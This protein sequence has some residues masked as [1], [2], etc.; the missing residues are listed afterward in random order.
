MTGINQQEMGLHD[1]WRA[2]VRRRWFIVVSA[3][4]TVVPAVALSV[5]QSPVYQ[6]EARMLIQNLPS[7]SV[8]SSGGGASSKSV[9]NEIQVLEGDVVYQRL[10]TDLGLGVDPPTVTGSVVGDTDV[11]AVTVR[12]GDPVTAAILANEYI[13]AY[14][15]STRSQAVQGM[16]AAAQELQSKITE[17]QAQIDQ[18]DQQIARSNTDDD[19]TAQSQRRILVDQQALFKQR[20]DQLQVDAALSSGGAQ[21][22][23]PATPPVEPVEPTPT[24][25]A[26]LALL[27]GLML[28]IVSALSVDYLDDTVRTA[29]DLDAIGVG[30]PVLAAVPAD[31]ATSGGPLALTRPASLAVEAYRS[32]RTGV[33]FLGLDKMAQV[34][35]VTSAMPGEG[36]STTSSNLAIVLAQAGHNVVL[37]DADLRKPRVHEIFELGMSFGLAE[38]LLGEDLEIILHPIDDR[39]S[40][41][42]S[43]RVPPNPSEML[44]GSRIGL[45]LADLRDRFDYII[46]DSPPTL[47]VSDSTAL[48][49]HVDGVLVVVQAGRTT[50]AQVRQT[51]T[52]LDRVAA[53]IMGFVLNRAKGRRSQPYGDGYGTA[54]ALPPTARASGKAPSGRRP[55]RAR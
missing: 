27:V 52:T 39:L 40:V 37:V 33:Q 55:D 7:D 4:C 13:D 50:S 38:G 45:L 41:I 49:R 43:G 54:Y 51:L 5:M 46:I 48:S 47:P 35:E 25:T 9:S 20:I 15:N 8:F 6:A 22:V 23:R 53:P 14:I 36:K 16:I 31:N 30:R 26:M 24:R 42:G 28:G 10:K 17:L 21:L 2:L 44:S 1:Y 12:S 32:L 19:T 34:I 29:E 3:F 11:I 18:L